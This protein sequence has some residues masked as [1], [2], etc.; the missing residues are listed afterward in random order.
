MTYKL[1][2]LDLD[3]TLLNSEQKISA[4]NFSMI[5]KAEENGV[6]IVIATGRMFNSALPYINRLDLSGPMIT[7]NGALIKE[8]KTGQIIDHTP[9]KKDDIIEILTIARDRDL[10][11][12]MYHN[13]QLYV[14]KYFDEA[15]FYENISGIKAKQI[16]SLNELIDLDIT[17]I[18]LIDRNK[19]S[20]K[21]HLNYFKNKYSNN[22][23]ISK[24]NSSYIDIMAKDVSKGNAL[25]KVAE[26][27]DIK[28][29]EIIAIGDS[30][31]DLKMLKIVGLGIAMENSSND[32]KNI[33]QMTTLNN[34]NNGVAKAINNIIFSNKRGISNA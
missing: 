16:N 7:Y 33:A 3:G 13:D 15:V 26:L 6:R 29:A 17:K 19:D 28:P 10:H 5:R 27:Y 1:L 25:L 11:I 23:S 20:Y 9:L 22:L 2:A 31:N 34:D 30:Y 8:A 18:L 32:I 14:E 12:N 24:S 21:T 4:K